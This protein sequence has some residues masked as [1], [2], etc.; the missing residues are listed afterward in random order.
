[1]RHARGSDKVEVCTVA[2]RG[3][4][5]ACSDPFVR[6]ECGGKKIKSSTKE[7]TLDPVWNETFAMP[8]TDG[9]VG[10]E[11]RTG[12][13]R[14]SN[15]RRS[16][17]LQQPNCQADVVRPRLHAVQVHG[18]GV[19]RSDGLRVARAGTSLRGRR[20][21]RSRH[22]PSP[23]CVTPALR[24]QPRQW[25]TLVNKEG[26]RDHNRGELEVHVQWVCEENTSKKIKRRESVLDDT[27]SLA[28]AKDEAEMA[29]VEAER[30][31]A[32]EAEAKRLEELDNITMK[33]GD[34]QIQVHIIEVRTALWGQR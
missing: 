30:K 13:N 11:S 28:E 19:F 2:H 32:A 6:I 31:K 15:S 8:C 14:P 23:P 12:R 9:C 25:L 5:A 3:C 4:C 17:A 7:D 34:Y 29:E 1:M 26:T 16:L 27:M 20:A 22:T 21:V 10:L 18:S 24:A 33:E